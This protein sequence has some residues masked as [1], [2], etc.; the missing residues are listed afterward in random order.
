MTVWCI[1]VGCTHQLGNDFAEAPG[2][3]DGGLLGTACTDQGFCFC[4]TWLRS[5][6]AEFVSMLPEKMT[7]VEQSF[8]VLARSFLLLSLL[9]SL[10]VQCFSG[11]R[12]ITICVITVVCVFCVESEL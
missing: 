12:R 9:F 2:R 5:H 7:V 4:Q 6:A 11:T 10:T 8:R 3:C 1:T